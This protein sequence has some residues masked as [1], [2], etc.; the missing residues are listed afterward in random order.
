MM[1]ST[2]IRL[3]GD[4]T[5]RNFDRMVAWEKQRTEFRDM[6][7]DTNYV[8]IICLKPMPLNRKE[9]DLIFFTS[10]SRIL[11]TQ[12]QEKETIIFRLRMWRPGMDE[13]EKN[14]MPIVV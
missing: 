14:Q 1:V 6:Y 10:F 9:A 3:R 12:K 2:R 5:R 7:E 8:W 11:T 4:S 13:S